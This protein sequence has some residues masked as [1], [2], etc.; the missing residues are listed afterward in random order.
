MDKFFEKMKE[1]LN[2]D[3]EISYEEFAGYY[4]ELMAFLRDNFQ[5]LNEEDTHKARYVLLN[6]NTNA[7]DRA[8]R[9]N[10]V[11]KKYKKMKEKSQVWIDATA[12]RLSQM[13]LSPKQ[14]EEGF[15]KLNEL[16]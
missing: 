10:P 3:T 16:V 7:E 14:I 1:Y 12:Y 5:D 4:E 13:G 8:K 9:K 11:A 15:A 2:M 6:L